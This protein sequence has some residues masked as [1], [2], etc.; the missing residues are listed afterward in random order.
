[1]HTP[2]ALPDHFD[3]WAA[4]EPLTLSNGRVVN[5]HGPLGRRLITAQVTAQ[6]VCLFCGVK[7]A[8]SRW[9]RGGHA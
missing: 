8:T 6:L 1:M 2:S 9:W 7:H 5:A 4:I 3:Q